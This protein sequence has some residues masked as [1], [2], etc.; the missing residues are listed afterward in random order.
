M[1]ASWRQIVFFAAVSLLAGLAMISSE[2]LWIDEGQT[3]HFVNQPNLGAWFRELLHNTKS[4]A[5]MPLG[6]FVAWLGGKIL[7]TSE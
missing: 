3:L 6:M 1:H 5:Q 4:E 7:G 2:S